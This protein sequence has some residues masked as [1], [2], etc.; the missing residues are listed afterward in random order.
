MLFLN[1]VLSHGMYASP[2]TMTPSQ[3]YLPKI[4]V[5]IAVFLGLWVWSYADA[6]EFEAFVKRDFEVDDDAY[7]F[8]RTCFTFF[9]ILMILYTVLA[10]W[11]GFHAL[12]AKNKS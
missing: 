3:F 8:E 2:E 10:A 5:C 1:L 11:Y 4:I 6:K 7:D 12:T 9:L